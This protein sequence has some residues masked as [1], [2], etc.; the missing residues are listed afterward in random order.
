METLKIDKN[1]AVRLFREVPKWF[2][3]MLINTFGKE[4]FS[5]KIT[6][7]IKS[8]DDICNEV[9]VDPDGFIGMPG[10]PDEIAYKKIKLI[11]S[12]LN[13][14]VILDWNNSN[15]QKWYP[16]F[17][18]ASGSGFSG[19]RS[20]YDCTF[21]SVGSRLCTD[22]SEKAQYIAKQFEA[23]YIDFMLNSK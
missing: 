6:D 4:T 19:S 7:R 9:G 11:T 5:G 18:L 14:G 20:T 13:E 2:Q 15:Q 16:Y 17:N 12:V 10:T 1:K 23:E 22:T 3:E 21:T 8:F